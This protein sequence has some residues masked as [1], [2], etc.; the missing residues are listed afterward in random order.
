MK[1]CE[2]F[3][4]FAYYNRVITAATFGGYVAKSANTL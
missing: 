4:I 1:I 2:S 3:R